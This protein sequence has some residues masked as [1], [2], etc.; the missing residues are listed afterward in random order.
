MAYKRR[1][2]GGAKRRRFGSKRRRYGRGYRRTSG[3]GG[4]VRRTAR[5]QAW[6]VVRRASEVKWQIW[7]PGLWPADPTTN[8]GTQVNWSTSG[9]L[10]A[11][12]FGNMSYNGTGTFA[13]GLMD[14]L[15]GFVTS[16]ATNH[17]IVGN[18][19]LLKHFRLKGHI[20][21][22]ENQSAA[23][24]FICRVSVIQ[25]RQSVDYNLT[26][27]SVTNIVN[28][29]ILGGAIGGSTGG[30]PTGWYSYPWD[31]QKVRVLADK[32]YYRHATPQS[33]AAQTYCHFRSVPVDIS[34]SYK[35]GKVM[36]LGAQNINN[37]GN[38][39]LHPI[40]IVFQLGEVVVS[41]SN[42]T[43]PNLVGHWTLDSSLYVSYWDM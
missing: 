6:S 1:R 23:D 31:R 26:V 9:L 40:L 27:N 13:P 30:D 19:I 4:Y 28:N 11:Q 35:R 38:Y 5:N 12:T 14:L 32:H 29:Y 36:H 10:T 3:K 22:N 34:F 37:S 21:V 17:T 7:Q 16:G 15:H 18:K 20:Q 24:E 41:G 33:V 42:P 25:P 39:W 2:Y 43:T 8:L